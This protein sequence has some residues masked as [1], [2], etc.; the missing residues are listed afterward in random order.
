MLNYLVFLLVRGSPSRGPTS[1]GDL[2]QR[3]AR[4]SSIRGVRP[5]MCLQEGWMFVFSHLFSS[6][7]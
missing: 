1:D 6:R 4:E 7:L 5:G 3:T 2:T